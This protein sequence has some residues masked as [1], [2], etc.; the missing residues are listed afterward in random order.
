MPGSRMTDAKLLECFVIRRDATAFSTL[1]ERH[2][3]MVWGV[4]R[5]I[6]HNHHDAED[7]FQATFLVLA[8]KAAFV[9][10]MEMVAGWLF[11]VARTTALKARGVV[12]RTRSRERQVVEMPDQAVADREGWHDLQPLLDQ[13]LSRLP[14][15]YRTV[16]VLCDLEGMTRKEAARQLRVPE[17]TIAGWLARAR[18][19]LANR[20]ARHGLAF[21]AVTLAG[22][23]TR[24]EASASDVVL[25]A[26]KHTAELYAGSQEMVSVGI[27]PQVTALAGKVMDTMLA[28]KLKVA[29]AALLSVA[30]V[31]CAAGLATSLLAQ[32]QDAAAEPKKTSVTEP[33]TYDEAHAVATNTPGY[34]HLQR[35]GLA[36]HGYHDL[37]GQFPRA[38]LYGPDG[39]T[40]YSWRVE[41]LPVLKHYVDGVDPERLSDKTSRADYSKLI[42]A[43]G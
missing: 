25:T 33:A 24:S 3:P 6:L 1:V 11:G 42:A 43:C 19:M 38:V 41:L 22:L 9:K 26:A 2:G 15:R 32:N 14:Q 20:L 7:A 8:R 35:I 23:M 37:F 12:G 27:S 13:E 40:P 18:T 5:R 28:F 21:S 34:K 31:T 36:F 10:P 29:A 30:V 17:G 39:K 16:I 4:C